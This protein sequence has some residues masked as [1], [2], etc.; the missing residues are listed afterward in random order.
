ME[1]LIVITG[2]TKG[3]GKALVL[4]FLEQKYQ[5]ITCAR[6]ANDL[7]NLKKELP[8]D[9]QSRLY[10]MP[11]DVAQRTQVAQFSQFILELKMPIAALINNA[12]L[13][14]ANTIHEED[15]K[16]LEMML[17]TN[18]YSAYWLTKDLLPT[19]IAQKNGHIF[20]M[21][22]TASITAYT[23]GGS[24]CIAKFALYGMTKVLRQEL[25][26]KNIKVTAILPGATFTDS[27][28]G[29]DLPE[30][31][32]MPAK[33]IANA[34]WHAFQMSHSTVVEEILIRP[35]LGDIG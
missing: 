5:V 24:Y 7:E 33:D 25:K 11:V 12:G 31:R 26:E 21:C 20:N 6:N 13:F 22:S 27:W 30:Q 3:I 18:L 14:I 2:G 23:N 17:N 28:S 1:K 19:I 10:T 8:Q 9:Q 32:F 4:L 34:V 16:N 15:E 35:Q 29:T